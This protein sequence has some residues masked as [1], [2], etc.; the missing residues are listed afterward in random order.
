MSTHSIRANRRADGLYHSYNLMEL[1]GDGVAVSHLYE[2]LEGQA[3]VLSS[4]VLS[5]AEAADLL[6]ALRHSRLYRADQASYM[7][8]PDRTLPG[9]LE[10]NNSR[11]RPWRSRRSQ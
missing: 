1:E 4:G 6:D 11:R 7:L 2:M 9:F 8:Y 3:A 10:K 5:G